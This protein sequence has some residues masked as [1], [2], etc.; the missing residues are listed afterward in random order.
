M[1]VYQGSP[2]LCDKLD[3]LVKFFFSFFYPKFRV[4]L[5][6]KP[7]V[8]ISPHLPGL[9]GERTALILLAQSLAELCIAI[10]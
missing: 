4:S 10:K 3:E 5:T 7:I 2:S 1:L 8:Q 6:L 9:L